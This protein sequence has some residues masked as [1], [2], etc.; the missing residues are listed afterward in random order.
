MIAVLL[1]VV[2]LTAAGC[3]TAIHVDRPH[4]RHAP[5]CLDGLPVRLLLDRDCPDGIC[6]YTCRPGRWTAPVLK[7]GSLC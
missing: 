7:E 5:R 3:S 1:A 4:L 6:G 2:V